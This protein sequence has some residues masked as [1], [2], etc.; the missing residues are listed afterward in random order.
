MSTLKYLQHYGAE[1]LEKVEHL[2]QN[3][4]I[5]AYL[6]RKYPQAHPYTTDAAL[7]EFV[8]TLKNSHLKNAP[9]LRSVRF[10]GKIESLHGALGTHHYTPR[11]Q[12]AKVKVTNAIRIASLFKQCPEPFLRMI[13]V[14]ELAHF[15]EKEHN[16][17]FYR[18]CTHI[19]PTYHQL[20]FDLRL[21]LTHLHR[22]PT[23]S[24]WG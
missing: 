8:H 1:L 15:R 7:H 4:G 10:D 22:A 17:A 6:G 21:Y 14:H 19:E 9:P 5:A 13:V 23:Q 20:E 3:E 24:L 2:I 11:I 12:G 16:K 18:L